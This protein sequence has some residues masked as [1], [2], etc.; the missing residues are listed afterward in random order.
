MEVNKIAIMGAGLVGSLLGIYLKRKG[1]AVEIFE[2]RSDMRL[3]GTVGGR[4]INLAISDRGWKA[5]AGVELEEEVR[6]LA[7]PMPGRMMHSIEGKLTYQPYG[8]EGEF[9]NS[10]SRGGL[11]I[12]LMNAAEKLGVPIHFNQR[13]LEINPFGNTALMQ[14]ESN[15]KEYQL[16][17][18]LIIGADGAFSMVRNSMM[19]TEGFNYS[20]LF[21]AHS[22]KEL[23]IPS[24][25]KAGE[26]L[27]EK[28]ALHIWPRKS[29]MMIA[30]PNLDGSFTVTLFAPTKGPESF[31]TLI[32]E[33]SLIEYFKK[34]FPDALPM[35]PDLVNDFFLN[36][37]GSLVTIKCYPWQVGNNLLI[38]DAAHAVVPFY[39][40]G[41]N[42]GFEDCTILND[43]LNSGEKDWNIIIEKFQQNRKPNADAI[44]DLAR[45]NFIEMRD[46]VADPE[47]LFKRK[48][49]AKIGQLYPEKFIPVYSMVSFTQLPYAD[50]LK[51]YT[52]QANVLSEIITMPQI[53]EKWDT[54]YLEEIANKL[55]I[56]A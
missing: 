2:R 8:K 42:C 37:T 50:A 7:I 10:V 36:P 35:M 33:K 45:L 51:E 11:N 30:L 26:F 5:L 40:Q 15:G 4:S 6:K 22:Y 21:E 12:V 41:M 31:E 13:V 49:S 16:S 29:F 46:L 19:K 28:N 55:I 44:A 34:Y 18:D 39:G 25:S 38:G 54:D 14:D 43:L 17:S 3:A 1:Y 20:Q 56:K 47:F 23:S 53:V 32:D 9:I 48:I 27:I 24:G 52:R